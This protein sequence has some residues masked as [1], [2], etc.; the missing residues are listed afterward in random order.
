MDEHRTAARFVPFALTARRAIRGP[1]A[2]GHVEI[3]RAER[4]PEDGIAASIR[5]GEAC[6][7]LVR[8]L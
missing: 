7:A 1:G 2:L 3:L 4:T 6:G 5:I 8:L